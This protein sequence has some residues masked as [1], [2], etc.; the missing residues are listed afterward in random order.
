MRKILLPA[1]LLCLIAA[2]CTMA[3]KYQQP[4]APVSA[5]WPVGPAYASNNAA[6]NRSATDV[7]WDEFFHDPRLQKIIGLALTNNRDLRV[8][9]LNVEQSRAQYR[10]TRA[11][12]LPSVNATGSGARQRIPGEVLS[13]G[14]SGFGAT[15]PVTYNTFSANVG[16][17]SYE[18]DLFGRVRSLNHQALET[19]FATEEARQSSQISLVAEV[20]TQYLTQIQSDEQLSLARQTLAAVQSSYD[21]NQKSFDVGSSS[22]LDLQTSKAQVGTAQANIADYERQ[23]A[24]AENALVLLVGQPIPTNLPGPISL[25]AQQIPYDLPPGLP[26]DLLLRRPDV[27]E[28]EH[29]L[30]AANANIG[31]ARAAFFPKIT[32]TG[33]AGY[34]SV[35]LSHLFSG[36]ELAWSFTPEITLPIF[37]GGKN[38][39]NLDVA[40]ISKRIDVAQYEKSIQSA[41]RE[42][43]DA[44]A[45]KTTLDRQIQA[46]TTVVAAEQKRYQLAEMRYRNGVENYL[47][48]LSAQQDLYSSQQQFLQLQLT[49]LSNLITLY[50]ALGGGWINA[51]PTE[52]VAMN[53][54]PSATGGK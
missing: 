25:E 49:R 33:S 18:L 19:F 9:V 28:A 41:F 40:N 21:L 1:F 23:R 12:L 2:G 51:A 8:A 43:A 27:L 3:P 50:K 20:A 29:T 16:V 38:R 53:G 39:A 42:V 37:N 32:L 45:A 14:F 30:K 34:E 31:A 11:D 35:K 10:I 36:P 13:A 48:V 6:T 54:N 7:P 22:E 17:T 47:T 15:G 26:S 52:G 44:L 5:N 46:Q 24:Q 4:V